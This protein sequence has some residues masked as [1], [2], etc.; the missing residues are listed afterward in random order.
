ML[1]TL[2][3]ALLHAPPVVVVVNV[4][5]SPT[6]TVDEPTIA[7]GEGCTVSVTVL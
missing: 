7:A 2:G 5:L 6:H 4:V 1:A 3:V